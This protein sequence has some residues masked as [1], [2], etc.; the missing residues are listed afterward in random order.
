VTTPSLTGSGQKKLAK[1]TNP[2]MIGRLTTAVQGLN[3]GMNERN[4]TLVAIDPRTLCQ[5]AIRYASNVAYLEDDEKITLI[6][7]LRK[8]DGIVDALLSM[9]GHTLEEA[10]VRNWL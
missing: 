8:D 4:A 7:V 6:E 2:E 5:D 10:T 9:R 3:D 1:P